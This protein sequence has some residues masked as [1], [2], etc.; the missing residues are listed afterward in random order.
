MNNMDKDSFMK[1]RNKDEEFLHKSLKQHD[2]METLSSYENIQQGMNS[3]Q[4]KNQRSAYEKQLEADLKRSDSSTPITSYDSGV[5]AQKTGEFK[6][7]TAN[8]SGFM[9]PFA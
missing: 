8:T 5:H 4:I 9:N 3:S 6:F 2:D 7:Q 1:Q